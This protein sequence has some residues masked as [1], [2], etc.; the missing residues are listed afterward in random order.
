MGYSLT[1][2][3]GGEAGSLERVTATMRNLSYSLRGCKYTFVTDG[4]F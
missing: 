2:R 4:T 3:P 1:T